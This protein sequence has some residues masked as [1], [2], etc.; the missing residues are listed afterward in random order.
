V[1]VGQR[2]LAHRL[3]EGDRGRLFVDRPAWQRAVV[4]VSGPA[5]H[6]VIAFGLLL[7]VQVGWAQPTGELTSVIAAVRY[8]SPAADA[9]KVEQGIDKHRRM[10]AGEDEPIT[11]R[12][13]GVGRIV[14][15]N[16]FPDGVCHRG[17]RHGSARMTAFGRLDGVHG[18][19]ADRVVGKAVDVGRGRRHAGSV[20]RGMTAEV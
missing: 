7:A 4:L 2:R 5:S 13:E 3:L 17:Q 19:R 14:S 8:G 11:I 15:K 18:E 12:P 1:L 20:G 16:V 6:L 10:A 9:R